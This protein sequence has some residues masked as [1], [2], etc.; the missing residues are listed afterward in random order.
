MAVTEETVEVVSCDDCGSDQ[1]VKVKGEWPPGYYGK[2]T[3]VT[4]AG[5]T[6]E[7]DWFACRAG[8]IRAAVLS[9]LEHEAQGG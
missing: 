1:I 3:Q 4:D 5:G 9:V 7:L 8:H 2:V 6:A